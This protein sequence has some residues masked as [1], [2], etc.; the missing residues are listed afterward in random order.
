MCGW[1]RNNVF[2]LNIGNDIKNENKMSKG[3]K[4]KNSNLI[5]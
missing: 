5:I 3:K 1:A 4:A 2:L